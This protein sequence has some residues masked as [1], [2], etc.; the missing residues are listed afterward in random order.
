MTAFGV[1]DEMHLIS[2]LVEISSAIVLES[3]ITFSL[4][5]SIFESIEGVREGPR[6][7]I[8]E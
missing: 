5:F 8:P 1:M 7:F 3:F 4:C 2:N 6:T